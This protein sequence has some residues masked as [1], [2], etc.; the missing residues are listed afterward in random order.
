MFNQSRLNLARW[1][2]LSMGG[3]LILFASIL[4]GREARDRLHLFDQ[5]LY[6]TGEVVASGAEEI[7]YGNLQRIDLESA[8]LL[9][10]DSLHLNTHI[11]YARWYTPERQILQFTGNIPAN[12]LDPNFGIQTLPSSEASTGL[13][14]QLT[15]P[16]YRQGRL[17]GYLQIAA[18]L[19]SVEYPLRQLR[20]FLALGVPTT[21]L[22]IAGTGWI[23][24]GIAMQP[25]QDAYQRLQQFTADASHELRTPLSAIVSNAQVAL[26][27]PVSLDEQT[28]CLQT[29][30]DAGETMGTLVERLLFLA[31]YQGGLPTQGLQ[32]IN[33]NDLLKP[34][35]NQ[36]AAEARDR[37]QEFTATFFPTPSYVYAEP[38]LI[39]QALINLLDNALR[40]TPPGQSIGIYCES[41]G[42]KALIHIK[43][44][45]IGIAEDELPHIFERFYRVNK[46]RSR[47]AGGYGLGLAIVQQIM[48]L[49]DGQITVTSQLHIGS[50]FTLRLPMV[51]PQRS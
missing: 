44:T 32:T 8:P 24:G 6:S 30:A 51:K 27:E 34:L 4:Y 13:V 18:S 22:I 17:L 16:V 29:I 40:Y 26:M 38:N 9:G 7:I 11:L 39:R 35:A 2:T 5:A 33:L 36:Y 20:L 12:T 25:I 3:I 41:Q 47:Q 10:S 21:L 31:R 19:D 28:A 43:D 14:R 46:V 42:A 49:H 45:G 37:A 23:L 50:Q 15:L 48:T 1:F